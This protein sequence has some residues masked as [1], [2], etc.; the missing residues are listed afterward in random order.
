M[1]LLPLKGGLIQRGLMLP[2]PFM[3]VHQAS[4]HLA[5]VDCTPLPGTQPPL[6]SRHLACSLVPKY[7]KFFLASGRM[8]LSRHSLLPPGPHTQGWF[9]LFTRQHTHPMLLARCLLASL[10]LIQFIDGLLF[11]LS[12]SPD[13]NQ[14]GGRDQVPPVPA[15]CPL[16]PK[17][18]SAPAQCL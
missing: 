18:P 3:R 16:L 13:C 2:V 5:P 9:L 11:G 7:A 4:H 6:C 14:Y 12:A 1:R 8:S 15:L 17:G 10:Y